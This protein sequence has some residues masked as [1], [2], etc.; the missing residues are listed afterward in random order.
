MADEPKEVSGNK[1][2]EAAKSDVISAAAVAQALKADKGAQAELKSFQAVDFTAKGDN[3]ASYVTSV[4][5]EY[6]L[7]GG[8]LQKVTYVVKCNPQRSMQSMNDIVSF[9]FKKETIFYEKIVPEI[10]AVF[11]SLGLP[12][13]KVPKFIYATD[14]SK[15]EL[16][17]FED[18]RKKNFRMCD[19]R[20]GLD[21]EH[22]ILVF[23]ELAHLHAAGFMLV[24]RHGKDN[25][26]KTHSLEEDVYGKFSHFDAMY[27][28]WYKSIFMNMSDTISTIEGYEKAAN[29]LKAMAPEGYSLMKGQLQPAGLF[30]SICHGDCWT[31][32]LLFRYE[33]ERPVEVRLLDFQVS[34]YA[35]VATDLQYFF[36]TSFDGPGRR[37]LE[38]FLAVYHS[39]LEEYAKTSGV[40]LNFSRSELREEYKAKSMY[41]LCKGL[42]AV[43]IILSDPADKALDIDSYT[44]EEKEKFIAEQQRQVL[45]MMKTNPLLHP[46]LLDMI[47][48]KMKDGIF[49]N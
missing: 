13:L 26:V 40:K 47:D 31:S 9:I 34:R 36:F 38:E 1:S 3:Y 15:G 49:I 6:C 33:N 14:V 16:I 18:L 2:K 29:S 45:K 37:G 48:E 7:P 20:K 5:V 27:K 12:N 23:K 39:E 21:R 19:R 32:N 44:D 28:N 8:D 22:A 35:S 17:F 41:G 24:E 46:R 10:N 43:P 30:S 4:E 11:K 42:G 25:L